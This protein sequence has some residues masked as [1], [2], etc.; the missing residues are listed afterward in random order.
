MNILKLKT[1]FIGMTLAL[2]GCLDSDTIDV[3]FCDDQGDCGP[4]EVCTFIIGEE[5]DPPICRRECASN[6]RCPL[7]YECVPLSYRRQ[8]CFYTGIWEEE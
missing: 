5:E 2:T 6:V 4:F 1:A 8:V 7:G 3:P